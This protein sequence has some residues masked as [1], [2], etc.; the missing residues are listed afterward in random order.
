VDDARTNRV[1]FEAML[2]KMGHIPVMAESGEQAIEIFKEQVPD[3]ALVDVM[4][5]GMD[6]Y[7]TV[8]AFRRL[9]DAW[10]P[11]VFVSAMGE[12][13]DIVRGIQV[14]AD[15][16][17]TKPV[18]YSILEVKIDSLHQRILMAQ[19]LAEQ[20]RQ[21]LEHRAKAEE[22]GH[23]AQEF[24][25][26]LA[27]FDKICDPL[28]NFKLMPAEDF[29][30]DLI[31][32]ARTPAGQLHI[33]LADSTGHGLTSALAVMPVLQPFQVMS[34]KGFSISAIASEINR[35][36][37]EYLPQNRF[38]AGILLSLDVENR[39][40]EVW[41]GGC[42]PAILLNAQG[43]IDA[44][45][46][47]THLPLG[48]LSPDDFDGMV[49]RYCYGESPC[50]VLM[51]SDGAVDC[52][53]HTSLEQGMQRLLEA[54]AGVS[55][56]GRLQAMES[57][58]E[59]RLEDLESRDDI[60]LIFVNCTVGDQAEPEENQPA[61]VVVSPQSGGDSALTEWRFALT[62]TAPQLKRL[63]VVP[64][65][66]SLVNQIES[67]NP[68]IAGKLFLVM[69]ELYN[70][71][72]DH[73]LLQLDSTLKHDPNGME[74]YY[75]QRS[76]RLK[77]LETGEIFIGLEKAHCEG[78]MCVRITF[79]DSGEGFDHQQ[80][81]PVADGAEDER[82]H[83]RGIALIRSLGNELTYVGNG[84]EVRVSLPL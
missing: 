33:M 17:L 34:Q 83:G 32:V 4:M 43:G 64:L 68:S 61:Q 74:R 42:P 3:I 45:F 54:V 70:N 48:I 76:S 30:G 8:R 49:E 22:E 58:L 75:E 26:R 72:L 6:G 9:S 84:S 69:S 2:K 12:N 39:M 27:A 55:P 29:S 63:D 13:Q 50:Q 10:I 59:A 38:V 46:D 15:D 62:L 23:L 56:E 5:P 36:V 28:V 81:K 31:A 37:K 35:K 65:L 78:G 82:R 1:V 11:I 60:A 24:M 80:M 25:R 77:L 40:V 14:G 52:A 67:D 41:N 51:S 71:A 16:Y 57:M 20:N 21:L 7:D 53:D 44:R 73:G 19:Q 47:S 79:R 66:L 18:N